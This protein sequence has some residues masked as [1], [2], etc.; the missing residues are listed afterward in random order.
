MDK[1]KIRE[2]IKIIFRPAVISWAMYDLANTLFAV[3]IITIVFPV[4]FR[5]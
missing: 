5:Y 4:Y 1:K 3:I 2:N